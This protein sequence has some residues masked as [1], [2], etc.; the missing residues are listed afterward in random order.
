MFRQQRQIKLMAFFVM[1]FICL[2]AAGA[3]CVA[4]CQSFDLRADTEHC[5]LAKSSERCDKSK[6]SENPPTASFA[7]DGDEMG[8]CPM[9]VS[10]FA[11]P[12]EKKQFSIQSVVAVP[13]PNYAPAPAFTFAAKIFPSELAYRGPPLDRRVDRLKH[14]VLRI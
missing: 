5:P 12:V 8:C 2:N 3:L 14:C 9:T 6:N 10:F 13:V 7:V 11:G 4:Y 1:A